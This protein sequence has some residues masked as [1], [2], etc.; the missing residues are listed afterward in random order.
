[1]GLEFV[2][3]IDLP[4]HAGRGGFDHGAVHR[5]RRGFKSP[6]ARH[7]LAVPLREAFHPNA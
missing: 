3:Y 7:P 1:M 4:E 2:R 5:R 6:R